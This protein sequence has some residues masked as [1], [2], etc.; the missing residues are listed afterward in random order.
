MMK[1]NRGYRGFGTR[2]SALLGVALSCATPTLAAE[3][4]LLRL[5]TF[6]D[7]VAVRSRYDVP[8]QGP[9]VGSTNLPDIVVTAI[10]NSPRIKAAKLNRK[11]A[12][13]DVWAAKGQFLPVISAQGSVT[14]THNEYSLGATGRTDEGHLDRLGLSARMPL[15]VGG[16]NVFGLAAAK[17]AE[18]STISQVNSATNTVVFS[19]VEAYLSAQRSRDAVALLSNNLAS[20]ESIVVVAG[21]QYKAGEASGTDVELAKS[22]VLKMQSELESAQSRL[23][24][25][26]ATL[27]RL[28]NAIPPKV[29]ASIT[30]EP[31]LPPTLEEAEKAAVRQN[32][33]VQS[34]YHDAAVS[35]FR[36]KA[37]QGRN[38]PS[39]NLL[40]DYSRYKQNYGSVS[41]GEEFSVKLQLDVPLLNVGVWSAYSA[42]KNRADAAQFEAD[43]L[44]Q[45]MVQGL[46]TDWEELASLQSRLQNAQGIVAKLRS[47][48]TGARGEFQAGLRS[49][50]DVLRAKIER[51]RAEIDA[52]NVKFERKR[53]RYKIYLTIG[54]SDLVATR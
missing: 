40:A 18:Q 5:Q 17:E 14:L 42:E 20:F 35:N 28:S 12:A 16:A 38:L 22:A 41:D 9:A 34:G 45:R 29:L 52:A 2:A 7:P 43:D 8:P 19:I 50:S 1:A 30:D 54:P 49:V 25:E 15:F 23:K 44:R 53:L 36:A 32:P 4:F 39:V 37:T 46:E 10:K 47:V 13:K 6:N 26:E 24:G 51:I 31:Q 11:A 33:D 21:Q 48:E 27:R 3:N